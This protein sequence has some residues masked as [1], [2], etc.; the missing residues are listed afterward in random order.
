MGTRGLRKRIGLA[1]AC[2]TVLVLAIPSA[3]ASAGIKY[4]WASAPI[5]P[6][7]TAGITAG[8]CGTN[9]HHLLDG[10]VFFSL[11]GVVTNASYPIDGSDG[12]E[13]PDD[14]WFGY[15]TNT[16]GIQGTMSVYATCTKKR[17]KYRTRETSFNGGD[18]STGAACPG[19]S[20]ATGAGVSPSGIGVST[21][22]R[23]WAPYDFSSNDRNRMS[24][25]VT[26]PFPGP[27]VPVEVTA[28]CSNDL[29][30]SYER[31][32]LKIPAGGGE[33]TFVK[34]PRGSQVVGGG[35]VNKR[36]G[37]GWQLATTISIPSDTGRDADT[38]PDDAWRVSI[39][40]E[41]DKMRTVPV[42][43]VCAG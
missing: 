41:S 21:F 37:A 23:T 25:V 22:A 6:G 9:K 33:Q 28:V 17:L 5:D 35:G 14:A 8:F 34:C 16:S 30:L 13:K 10:G 15:V 36:T 26:A 20:K 18:F 38:Q 29:R 7:Q 27:E 12:D 31:G 4:A 3:G 32:K 24:A 19:H 11:G 39:R 40:S 1:A 2:A 43:A 42:V